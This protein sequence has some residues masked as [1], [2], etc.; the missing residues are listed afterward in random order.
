MTGVV[1][2]NIRFSRITLGLMEDTGLVL[3]Q[4]YIHLVSIMKCH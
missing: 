2:F 3:A 4:F 1:L